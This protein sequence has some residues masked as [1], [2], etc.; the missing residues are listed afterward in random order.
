M[1]DPAASR[2]PV[3]DAA[4]LSGRVDLVTHSMG[5]LLARGVLRELP[6]PN[7]GRLVMLAPPNHGAQL[8]SRASAYAWARGFYGQV[9]EE[10]RPERAAALGERIGRPACPFGVIAGTRAFHPLQ[11]TSYVTSLAS[12]AGAAGAHDGTVAV[13]ETRLPGMSDFITVDANHMFIMEH[14]DTIRQTLHFLETGSFLHAF[15]PS[16]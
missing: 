12:R 15:P 6:A 4:A 13:D 1:T 14:D 16:N 8:A 9:L 2:D 10:L 11:P 3:H 7:I 5:G